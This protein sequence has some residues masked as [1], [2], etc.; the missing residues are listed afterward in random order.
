MKV[1]ETEASN[2][3]IVKENETVKISAFSGSPKISKK[4]NHRANSFCRINT[5]RNFNKLTRAK[6]E[7]ETSEA[8]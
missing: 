8:I 2:A 5:H 1:N 4:K 6:G 3:D 7:A